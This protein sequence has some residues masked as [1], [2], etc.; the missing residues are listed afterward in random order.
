VRIY[1]AGPMRGIPEFNRPAFQAG[2]KALRALG[3]EVFS[4]VEHDEECGFNWAGTAGNLADAEKTQGFSLRKALSGDLAWICVH[5]DAVVTLPG[6]E[7]SLGA[8][9]ETATA[10]ALGLGVH[11]LSDFLKETCD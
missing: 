7:R 4:P 1:L 10:K 8:T 2:T 3:H 5:A 6:W 11:E 9:A